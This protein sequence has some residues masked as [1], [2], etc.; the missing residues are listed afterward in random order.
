VTA[1]DAPRREKIAARRGKP[2]PRHV[3]E[4]LFESNRSRPLSAEHRR[5][6]SAAHREG[7]TRPPR[8]GRPRTPEEDAL[9]RT[10]PGTVAAEKT[11]RPSCSVWDRRRQLKLP[12]GG[13]KVNP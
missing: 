9:V 1:L 7:D 5:K 2:R 12:D 10:L 6:L 4:A 11:G 3:V 13:K 8:A